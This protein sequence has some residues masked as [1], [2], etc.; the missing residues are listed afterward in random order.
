[1]CTCNGVF[2]DGKLSLRCDRA[3]TQPS[4]VTSVFARRKSARAPSMS[5]RCSAIE[6]RGRLANVQRHVA[7]ARIARA[8]AQTSMLRRASAAAF[9]FWL[10]CAGRAAG[11]RR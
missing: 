5:P 3:G 8:C 1:M 4:R 10:P 11:P 6:C 7:G 9:W 2:C